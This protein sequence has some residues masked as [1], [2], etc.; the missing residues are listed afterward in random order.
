MDTLHGY[1]DKIANCVSIHDEKSSNGFGCTKYIITALI[2]IHHD[3][4]YL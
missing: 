4:N 1:D 3:N 2:I